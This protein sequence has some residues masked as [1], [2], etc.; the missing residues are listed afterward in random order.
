MSV[1]QIF[2]NNKPKEFPDEHTKVT[3]DDSHEFHI[4]SYRGIKLEP[5]K[6]IGSR[7]KAF[8]VFVEEDQT[9]Y[10]CF[11]FEGIGYSLTKE[12]LLELLKPYRTE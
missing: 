7:D 3:S 1:H 2:G 5:T 4:M 12:K 9:S 6:F 11:V 8:E 10:M